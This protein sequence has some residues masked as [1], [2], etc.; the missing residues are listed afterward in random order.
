MMCNHKA[1]GDHGMGRWHLGTSHSA[2]VPG[3]THIPF[4]LYWLVNISFS[5]WSFENQYI[6]RAKDSFVQSEELAEVG[7]AHPALLGSRR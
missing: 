7:A 6:P 1:A 5:F 3:M 4:Y 2:C